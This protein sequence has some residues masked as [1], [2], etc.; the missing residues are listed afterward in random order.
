SRSHI[1][2]AD[3][4]NDNPQ[5]HVGLLVENRVYN[6][7]NHNHKVVADTVDTFFSKCDCVYDGDDISLYYGVVGLKDG[8]KTPP[9]VDGV[10]LSSDVL[11]HVKDA[12]NGLQ[13]RESGLKIVED[14]LAHFRNV[15]ITV[16][17]KT[18]VGELFR[19]GC[20]EGRHGIHGIHIH[21]LAIHSHA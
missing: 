9:P 1:N 4:M 21:P 15:E 6:Y 2:R 12:G 5:K 11:S 20:G 13:G 14:V 17:D 18:G 10:R 3:L 19:V 7:S 8:S 16:L